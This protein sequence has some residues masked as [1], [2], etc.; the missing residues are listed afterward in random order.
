M[1]IR[2]PAVVS[3]LSASSTDSGSA[4]PP[5]PC[6]QAE[7]CSSTLRRPGARRSPRRDRWALGA[8]GEG[9]PRGGGCQPP[10]SAAA[11]QVLAHN[12]MLVEPDFVANA[13]GIVAACV[14][15]E[16]RHSPF[17]PESMAV[18][19]LVAARLRANTSTFLDEVAASGSLPHDAP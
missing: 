2:A 5:A 18:L 9:E 16:A 11:L 6:R 13:G 19:D 4:A 8:R 3:K 14:A 1:Y 12:N 10:A 7:N 15:M 17:R